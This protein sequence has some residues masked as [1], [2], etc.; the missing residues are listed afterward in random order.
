MWLVLL[1]AAIR[2]AIL[3]ELLTF[4]LSVLFMLVG[5][6]H[7]GIDMVYPRFYRGRNGLPAGQLERADEI[8]GG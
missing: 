2:A 6:E 3:L 1:Q 7:T 5:S 8:V 4:S